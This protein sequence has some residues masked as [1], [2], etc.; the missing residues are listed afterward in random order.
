LEH[1]RD[2]H[3]ALAKLAATERPSDARLATAHEQIR[4]AEQR[5]STIDGELATLAGGLVDGEEI[6]NALANFEAVW[7][8]LAPRE[9]VRIVELLVERVAYDSAGGNISITFHPSG[10]QALGSEFAKRKDDAA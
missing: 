6:S 7:D 1:L 4:T 10:I 3:A 5:Q 8:C 9:Q 2:G